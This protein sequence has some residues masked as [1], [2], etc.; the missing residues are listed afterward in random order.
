MK[1]GKGLKVRMKCPL[2]SRLAVLNPATSRNQYLVYSCYRCD[3][4]WRVKAGWKERFHSTGKRGVINMNKCRR[5]GKQ[6]SAKAKFC[7]SC[8]RIMHILKAQLLYL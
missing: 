5:C 7:W 8:Y 4:E 2:C 6:C 1:L 3:I